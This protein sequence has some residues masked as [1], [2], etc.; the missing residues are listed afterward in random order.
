MIHASLENALAYVYLNLFAFLIQMS[1]SNVVVHDPRPGAS[2]G[3]VV[4]S[5]TPDRTRI[6]QILIHGFILAEQNP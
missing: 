2:E 3:T 4:V 5:G 6:A 1:G